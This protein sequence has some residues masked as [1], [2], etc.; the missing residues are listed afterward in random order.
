M[1]KGRRRLAGG[2]LTDGRA[3][4]VEGYKCGGTG[5]GLGSIGLGWINAGLAVA[6]GRSDSRLLSLLVAQL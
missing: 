6:E 1:T 2:R 4:A 5:V 3:R